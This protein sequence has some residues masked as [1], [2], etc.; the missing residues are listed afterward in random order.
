MT[1][2]YKK[3]EIFYLDISDSYENQLFEIK[4]KLSLKDTIVAFDKNYRIYLIYKTSGDTL[5]VGY[6]NKNTGL[7][8]FSV[9]PGN[10]G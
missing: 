3:K 10:S 2:G 8:S 5:D 7:Y 9:F 4:G 1:T 6:P